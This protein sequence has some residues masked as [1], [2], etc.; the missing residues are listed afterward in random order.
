MFVKVTFAELCLDWQFW[1]NF[2]LQLFQLYWA[3]FVEKLGSVPG[4]ASGVAERV[5]DAG[6]ACK[7]GDS[8]S[9]AVAMAAGEQSHL[10]LANSPSG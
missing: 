5:V 10:V 8:R 9:N 6:W 2:A 7:A 1:P 4:A 3:P